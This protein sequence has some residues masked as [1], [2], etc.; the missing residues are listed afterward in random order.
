MA[1]YRRLQSSFWQDNFVLCLSTE[2]KLFYMYL[3]TNSRTNQCGIYSFSSLLAS[4][5]LDLTQ[6]KVMELLHKFIYRGKILYDK[7]TEEI[8]ILNWYKY[9]IN[10]KKNIRAINY[11][12]KEVK[13]YNF[14]AKLYEL[15]NTK[16]I[17][18]HNMFKDIVMVGNKEKNELEVSS[19]EIKHTINEMKNDNNDEVYF[20]SS[21]NNIDKKIE[22][23]KNKHNNNTMNL[24]A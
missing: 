2:E 3:L 19:E 21:V 6:G 15:C 10:S 9:N 18:M 24:E 1:N 11:E 20:K 16:E 5:E 8:M 17:D 14:I 23:Y 12:L 22:A 4:I 7:T 13:T